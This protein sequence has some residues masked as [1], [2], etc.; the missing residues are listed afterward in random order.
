MTLIV[1][2]VVFTEAEYQKLRKRAALNAPGTVAAEVRLQLHMPARP[3][4]RAGPTYTTEQDY[5]N[6]EHTDHD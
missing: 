5:R 3:S 6:Q 1:V 2:Q 4:R